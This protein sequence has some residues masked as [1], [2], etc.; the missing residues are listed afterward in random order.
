M[1]SAFGRHVSHSQSTILKEKKMSLS[2]PKVLVADPVSQSGVDELG[3][4]EADHWRD[5]DEGVFQRRRCGEEGG[6]AV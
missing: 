4:G 1:F 2:T 3:A 6:S 5:G